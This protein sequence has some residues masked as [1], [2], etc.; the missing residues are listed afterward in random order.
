MS[1]QNDEGLPALSPPPPFPVPDKVKSRSVTLEDV[2]DMNMVWDHYT[3]VRL[4]ESWDQERSITEIA[5]CMAMT[6]RAIEKHRDHLLMP[7]AHR[8]TASEKATFV[9]PL[10]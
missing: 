2:Q 6:H 10:E 1:S 8:P 5:K 4:A 9:Y 3:F 7:N